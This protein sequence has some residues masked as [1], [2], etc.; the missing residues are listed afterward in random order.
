MERCKQTHTVEKYYQK[1]ET[2][3]HRV[4]VHNKHYDEAYFVTKFVNGLKREIRRATQLH[5][6][7]TVDAALSLA[8]TQEELLEE[9]RTFS[10]NCS[11]SD[12]RN[13]YSRTGYPGK[14]IMGS[15]PDEAKKGDEKT[16]AT[17]HWNEK[18]KA[19]K[20]Q[21]KEQG[22]VSGVATSLCQDTNVK[23][24]FCYTWSK[25]CGRCF[26]WRKRTT[27]RRTPMILTARNP[28]V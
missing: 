20:A 21:R 24:L 5:K 10:Y 27:I 15:T 26:N 25:N 11:N 19:L 18:L 9:G 28:C 23:K 17:A 22:D 6:P 7:K 4:L 14:G 12:T 8:E 16:G 1:F 2:L 3:R 13:S